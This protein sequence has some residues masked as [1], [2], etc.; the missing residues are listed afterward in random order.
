MTEQQHRLEHIKQKQL[1][2]M[3]IGLNRGNQGLDS[4]RSALTGDSSHSHCGRF[5]SV[6]DPHPPHSSYKFRTRKC[7]LCMFK[8][9]NHED[10]YQP[11]LGC[12][13]DYISHSTVPT[14][15]Q[16]CMGFMLMWLCAAS[17]NIHFRHNTRDIGE[18]RR[19]QS[20]WS[21]NGGTYNAL[22]SILLTNRVNVVASSSC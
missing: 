18:R 8:W 7:R 15:K 10:V 22:P 13:L 3:I 5:G 6:R 12:R 19:K 21:M 20:H 1:H 2:Y 9:K 4:I 17:G 11:N 14:C 16:G